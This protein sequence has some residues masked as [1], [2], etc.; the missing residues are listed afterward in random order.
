MSTR[1]WTG[2]MVLWSVSLVAPAQAVSPVRPV[3]GKVT[4][5]G[6]PVALR[7][8]YLVTGDDRLQTGKGNRYVNFTPADHSAVIRRCEDLPCAIT[9]SSGAVLQAS[10]DGSLWFRV[11]GD[12]VRR[13][14]SVGKWEK[15]VDQPKRLAAT[16]RLARSELALDVDLRFDATLVRAFP[17]TPELA[18]SAKARPLTSGG[19][20]PGAAYLAYCKSQEPP[21]LAD[22]EKEIVRQGLDKNMGKELYDLKYSES[23]QPRNC[24]VLEAR[25]DDKVAE[26]QVEATFRAGVFRNTVLMPKKNGRWEYQKE[27]ANWQRAGR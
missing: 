13:E 21:S 15:T 16:L 25:G 18:A 26:L 11:A 12:S 14:T 9:V 20:A 8:A 10:P 27:K 5:K 2:A 7:Y 23:D 22:F 4:M 6:K 19:G 24:R 1:S 3:S 17:I